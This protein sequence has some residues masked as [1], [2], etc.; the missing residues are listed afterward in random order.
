LPMTGRNQGVTWN[1]SPSGPLGVSREAM[2]RIN[3]A[4]PADCKR[5]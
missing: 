3:S 2:R 4:T 5:N 1:P